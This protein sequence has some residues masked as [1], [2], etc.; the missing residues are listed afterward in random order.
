MSNNPGTSN[1]GTS[2][3]VDDDRLLETIQQLLVLP[4]IELRPTLDQASTLVAHA[5]DAE[6]VDVF[7]YEADKD[8][9]VALGTSDTPM[10]HKQHALG[11]DRF[12]R[13]N[14][15]PLTRVFDSGDPYLTG[16]AEDDPSQP[17]GVVEE[18]GVRSQVD[19]P[20]E[21]N[22]ERRGVLAVVSARS[23]KFT[24]R[25]QRFLQ[26]VAAWIGLIIHRA[27]LIEERTLEAG[28]QGRRDAGDEVARITRRQQEVAA[29]R[30][31][32][33]LATWAV[34]RGIYRSGWADE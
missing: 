1:P 6:K 11:L 30:N 20:L 25:D 34:E 16:H 24:E 10:G 4:G 22:G 18:L 12:P 15:G 21:V 23:E 5:C 13:A 33:S 19:V 17:R 32:T 29:L 14:A 28:R 2:P 26:A 31:R 3:F 8:S 7:V 27:Q 9:L